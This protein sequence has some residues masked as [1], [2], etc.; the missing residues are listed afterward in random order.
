MCSGSG[1]KIFGHPS[2]ALSEAAAQNSFIRT[3][4]RYYVYDGKLLIERKDT[5]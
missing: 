2:I 4:S 1:R 3:F 5:H